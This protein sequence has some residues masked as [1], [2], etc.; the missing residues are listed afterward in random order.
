MRRDRRTSVGA[1]YHFSQL[2]R[3]SETMDTLRVGGRGEAQRIGLFDATAPDEVPLS[4]A[5]RRVVQ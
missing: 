5:T 2:G 1:S 3:G 4:E